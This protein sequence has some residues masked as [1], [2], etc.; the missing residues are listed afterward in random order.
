[1]VDLEE[2]RW[3]M[4]LHDVT[5]FGAAQKIGI[6]ESAMHNKLYGETEFT[7][8]EVGKLARLLH[9]DKDK[10]DEIFFSEGKE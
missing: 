7:V 4:W 3:Q 1:M 6:S 5:P 10:R 8:S 9:L 2:L